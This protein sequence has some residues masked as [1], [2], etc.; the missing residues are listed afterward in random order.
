[1][2]LLCLEQ[3]RQAELMDDPG[4]PEADHLHALE[5]LATINA[6][7]RTAIQITAA[8]ASL[9]PRN[10]P[11]PVQVVDLACG[12]GDVTLACGRRLA[13]SLPTH[14]V[15][16]TGVDMSRRGLGRA[17]ARITA[18][19][20]QL[21]GLPLRFAFVARDLI[22]SGCPPCDVA[23]SSLFFHHLDDGPAIRVL[24]SMAASCR[25]GFVVS[26]LIRSRLGLVMAVL[27]TS[28]LSGSRVARVDGPLSVRA[29]RTPAEY[30]RLLDAAGLTSATIRRTWPE[31][32]LITWQREAP[33]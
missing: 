19:H 26:D 32:V 20:E 22:A 11:G 29:A 18:A 8:A 17:A 23:I 10:D 9:L 31:R 1:M 12:G 28:L 15:V 24:Q 6:V 30:R 2:S 3:L 7:S 33:A 21:A 13:R 25:R 4:L 14:E 5:A 16:M 27:G